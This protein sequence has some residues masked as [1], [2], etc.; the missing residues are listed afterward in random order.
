MRNNFSHIYDLN[1]SELTSETSIFVTPLRN[2]WYS[3]GNE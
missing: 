2:I 3:Y 1:Q